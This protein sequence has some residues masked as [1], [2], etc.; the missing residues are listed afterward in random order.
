MSSGWGGRGYDKVPE[1][2]AGQFL[3]LKKKGQE[4]RVRLV[5]EPYLFVDEFKDREGNNKALHK[6]AWVAI[7]KE[8]VDGKPTKRVVVFEAGPMVLYAVRDLAKSEEWGDPAMYDIK[9]TRTEDAG[10][11][12]VITPLPKPMGPIS[13]EDEAL[14]KAA[15]LKLEE[16]CGGKKDGGGRASAADP[17]DEYDPFADE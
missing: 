13:D 1:P 10:K 14:V 3:R 9:I 12:Y 11:Y 4:V 2:E 6:A 8:I 16:L 15:G 7:S 5:S 17:H